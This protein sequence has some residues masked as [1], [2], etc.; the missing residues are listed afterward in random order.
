MG[1]LA[2]LAF[3]ATNE[4][5]PQPLFVAPAASLSTDQLRAQR[6]ST[7][8]AET[9]RHKIIRLSRHTPFLVTNDTRVHLAGSPTQFPRS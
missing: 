8:P 6:L 4:K 9:A 5:Q 2:C 3:V 7:H 1:T